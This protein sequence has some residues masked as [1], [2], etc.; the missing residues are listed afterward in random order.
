ML[1]AL[2]L[3][4]FV[5]EPPEPE[6]PTSRWGV[7]AGT[8]FRLGTNRGVNNAIGPRFGLFRPPP[9]GEYFTPAIALL[10]EGEI[11]TENK[12]GAFGAQLRLELMLAPQGGLL[13]PWWVVWLSA[14]A[15]AAWLQNTSGTELF[16]LGVGLGGNA[17]ADA[18]AWGPRYSWADWMENLAWPLVLF[19][20]VAGL[21][22]AML[23]VEARLSFYPQVTGNTIWPSLLIGFG[24]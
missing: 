5:E 20:T 22:V 10:V 18:G 16:H 11:G 15:G 17:F 3:T 6:A 12:V 19:A 14:G 8:T 2:L 24:M 23:R 1:L 21:P 13:V 7:A 4:V 9:V